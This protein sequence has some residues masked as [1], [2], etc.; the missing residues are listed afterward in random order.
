MELNDLCTEACPSSDDID[1]NLYTFCDNGCTERDCQ[2]ERCKY[3][4]DLLTNQTVCDAEGV[5]HQ[6]ISDYCVRKVDEG[7]GYVTC[8]ENTHCTS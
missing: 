6:T 3:E 4:T 1:E 5:F 2:L 8:A 7:I